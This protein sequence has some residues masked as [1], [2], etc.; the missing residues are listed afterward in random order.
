VP[1]P[2][3]A[4]ICTAGDPAM[5][6][7]GTGNDVCAMMASVERF[8]TCSQIPSTKNYLL[9]FSV[10]NAVISLKSGSLTNSRWLSGARGVRLQRQVSSSIKE[11]DCFDFF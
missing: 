4:P 11:Q 3:P 10:A 9:E 7:G 5:H 6:R 2:S 8:I 1:T